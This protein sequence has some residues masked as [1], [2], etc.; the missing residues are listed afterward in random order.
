[1]SACPKCNAETTWIENPY[2][3]TKLTFY[4]RG[5]YEYPICAWSGEIRA[6]KIRAQN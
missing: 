2:N 5:H 3:E 4:E 6:I 1:M